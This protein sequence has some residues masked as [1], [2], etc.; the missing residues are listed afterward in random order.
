MSVDGIFIAVGIEP[1][2]DLAVKLGVELENGY[3]KVDRYQRTNVEGVFAC[4]DC[5]NN[6]LKQVITACGEG[7]VAANSVYRLLLGKSYSSQ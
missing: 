7:A 6:P 3:I 4:G 2:V 5:C 1:N